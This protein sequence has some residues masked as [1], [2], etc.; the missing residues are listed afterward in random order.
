MLA[1]QGGT[2]AICDSPPGSRRL[3]ID[4]DHATGVVRGLLCPRCNTGLAYFR[5]RPELFR[6][7]ADYLERTAA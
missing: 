5:D 4:H 3:A 2:C 6:T 7:A 1:A